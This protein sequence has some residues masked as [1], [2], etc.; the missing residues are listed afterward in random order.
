MLEREGFRVGRDR[1]RRLWRRHGLRVPRRQI[2]RKSLG[3]SENSVVRRR[4]EH[5]DHVWTY[6]FVSDQTIDGRRLKILTIKGEFTRECLA[7]EVGRTFT[8]KDIVGVL[9]ELFLIRGRPRHARSDKGPEFIAKV[10][11]GW[12]AEH[13]I[14]MLYIKPGS[15]WENGVGESF[16]GKLRDELLNGELFT[17]LT[18]ARVVLGDHRQHYNHHR[19]HS[20][21]AY[22]P[23]A[24]F[25]SACR[26]APPLALTPS[27]ACTRKEKKIHPVTLTQPGT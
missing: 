13:N 8:G 9:G 18:E 3:S 23:P 10:V 27:P 17:S 19:P 24:S 12:L 5:I 21:L 6:D 22:Q 26:P 15:P 11:Q 1:V 4:A 20:S 2:K 7:L 25:A 14:S 16:N